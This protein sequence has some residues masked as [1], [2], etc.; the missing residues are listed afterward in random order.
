MVLTKVFSI[1]GAAIHESLTRTLG[2]YLEVTGGGLATKHK[3]E[4]EKDIAA[5]MLGT[6]NAAEAPFATVRALLHIYPRSRPFYFPQIN[7]NPNP[8]LLHQFEIKNCG[9]ASGSHC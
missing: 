5:R 2:Q 8:T 7:P 3:T 9:L 6:N 1:F 4:W